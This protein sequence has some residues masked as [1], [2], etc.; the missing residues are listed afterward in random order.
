MLNS[1][2]AELKVAIDIK[3]NAA[4]HLTLRDMSVHIMSK[5]HLIQFPVGQEDE[6]FLNSE[7]KEKKSVNNKC[8]YTGG[9]FLVKG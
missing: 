4:P 8:L 2:L 3:N 9:A 1:L 6:F 7:L 5:R